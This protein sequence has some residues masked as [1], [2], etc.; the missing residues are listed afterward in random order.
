[1]NLAPNDVPQDV[2]SDI[3][4]LVERERQIDAE[5]DG[6]HAKIAKILEGYIERKVQLV[7]LTS[8]LIIGTS[9]SSIFYSIR[10]KINLLIFANMLISFCT[11]INI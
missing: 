7:L 10:K 1:M 11:D 6:K 9:F 2:Y 3:V 8:T 4:L 5:G